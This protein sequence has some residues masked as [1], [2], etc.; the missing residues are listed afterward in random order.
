MEG[1]KG[2]G[3]KGGRR[4]KGIEVGRKKKRRE[5]EEAQC[6]YCDKY[7]SMAQILRRHIANHHQGKPYKRKREK[8]SDDDESVQSP[9]PPAP[10]LNPDVAS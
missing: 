10:N 8:K 9:P 5:E 6:P 1:K 7:D 2:E 4:K 3:K